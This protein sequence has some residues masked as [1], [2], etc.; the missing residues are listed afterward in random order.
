MSSISRSLM[1]FQ[2]FRLDLC[3]SQEHRS[4]DATR[5]TLYY[6][7]AVIVMRMRLAD[8]ISQKENIMNYLLV[9]KD[10]ISQL[11]LVL[12]RSVRLRTARTLALFHRTICTVPFIRQYVRKLS[13]TLF[14]TSSY[15]Y[16]LYLDANF[17]RVPQQVSAVLLGVAPHLTSLVLLVPIH[18]EILYGF[19]SNAYPLLRTLR[20]FH[21]YLLEPKLC[22]WYQAQLR[23][24]YHYVENGRRTGRR[25]RLTAVNIPN[26][27]WPVLRQVSIDFDPDTPHFDC[28]LYDFR[29]MDTVTEVFFRLVEEEGWE[30]NLDH[31]LLFIDPPINAEVIALMWNAMC[32][33]EAEEDITYLFHPNTVIPV[34]ADPKTHVLPME[35]GMEF[36]NRLTF[37]TPNAVNSAAFWKKA[38]AFIRGRLVRGGAGLQRPNS[39]RLVR[40]VE[41]A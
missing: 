5:T 6:D 31:Y 26:S 41:A 1:H 30:F 37:V 29:Y 17:R 7:V 14:T 27:P 24:W 40:V 4:P 33:P 13:I 20:I 21:N 15:Q 25:P 28:P 22:I 16:C 10:Y 11:R 18:P 9:S 8:G 23:G 36:F 12:Y 2:E 34:L 35:E 39:K 3:G 19:R 38:K 32:S